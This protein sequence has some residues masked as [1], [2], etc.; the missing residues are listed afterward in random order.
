VFLFFLNNKKFAA[1]AACAVICLIMACYFQSG[2]T[3]KLSLNVALI[4]HNTDSSASGYESYKKSLDV[5]LSLSGKAASNAP[6]LI[7]WP[8]TAFVPSV[9]WHSKY[10]EDEK[11]FYL[12]KQL[13]D[14]SLTAGIPLLTGNNHAEGILFTAPDG[15][16]ALRRS[17]YNSALLIRNG[18][19]ESVYNKMLLVPFTE[20]YPLGPLFPS[21]KQWLERNNANSWQ[22]GKEETV[23]HLNSNTFTAPV[24]FEILFPGKIRN[25]S[26]KSD[27]II[28]ISNESWAKSAAAQIQTVQAA[29]FRAAENGITILR[30]ANSG[31]TVMIDPL[32]NVVSQLEPFSAAFLETVPYAGRKTVYRTAGDWFIVLMFLSLLC[33][34]LY[35]FVFRIAL[36]KFLLIKKD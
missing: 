25:F 23:F 24:C 10:R 36:L 9:A 14:Y 30:A 8:E 33:P 5:L 2:K 18:T 15:R 21:F 31:N 20:T 6:D 13:L 28:N 16:I 35:K 19:V 11:R 12:V 32:G 22:R 34:F 29:A 27:F 17:D 3:E 1:A 26:L 7:V 4:Q